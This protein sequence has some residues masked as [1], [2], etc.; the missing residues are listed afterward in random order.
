MALQYRFNELLTFPCH[1]NLRIIV[2]ND[3]SEPVHLIDTINEIL[4]GSTSVKAVIDSRPSKT[5]KYTSYTVKV[6][7]ESAEQMEQLYRELPEKD[8]VQHLL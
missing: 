8:F 7:F 2:L 3:H 5:G 4:P 6:R 1:Q